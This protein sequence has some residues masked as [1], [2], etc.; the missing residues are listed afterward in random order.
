MS[1]RWG[2]LP[3][4]IKLNLPVQLALFV[5]LPAAHLWV[6][7]QYESVV[8]KDVQQRTRDRAIQSMLALNSMMLASPLSNQLA[9]TAFLNKVGEQE[10]VNDFHMVRTLAV[11][12]QFA[13]GREIESKEDE[14]DLLAAATGS[15]QTV[16]SNQGGHTLRMVIPFKA[17]RE[18]YGTDCLKC[19]HV[20]EGT[21]LG[22]ISQTVSLES[23]DNRINQLSA[24]LF[25]GQALLQISMFFLIYWLVRRVA[26]SVI[27]LESVVL[28]VKEFGD[29]SRR[30]DVGGNDEIGQIAQ[31]FNGFVS[32]IEELQMRLAEKIST[33]EQYHEQT[34]HE[35]RVGSDIMARINDVQSTVDPSVRMKIIPADSYSGDIIL[36]SRSQRNTLY[37]MLADAVGHGLIAAMNLL[38]L[39]QAFKAMAKKGFPLVRI[40]EELNSKINNL[41]PIDRFVGA[42]LVSI[43]FRNRIIE[44]WNGGLPSPILVGG[45]GGIL[46][47]WESRNLPLGI[48]SEAEFSPE[49]KV[50][51]YEVDCQLFV[52]SDGLT[53]ARSPAGDP[54]GTEYVKQLLRE[55]NPDRRFDL[56]MQSLEQHLGGQPAHDD[57]SVFMAQLSLADAQKIPMQQFSD[58]CDIVS[59]AGDWR[60]AISLGVEELKYLDIASMLAQMA[61]K[62]QTTAT[63]RSALYE[64]LSELFN[65][66]LDHGILRLHSAEKQGFEGFEKYLQQR[67]KRLRSLTTGL[68]EIEIEK[69]VIENN[70]GIRIH[71]FDSGDGFDYSVLPNDSAGNAATGQHGRG[72][73]LVRSLSCELEY[74]GKGNEVTAYYVID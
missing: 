19:H 27:N 3:L 30:A 72:I 45:H 24:V 68:I 42:V 20:P 34:Q 32:H 66:A 31:V 14:L 11:Q 13:P 26:R 10:G 74:A 23:V 52:F 64:I 29:F 41:M 61:D 44:I 73:A 21:V 16:I 69:I 65:N 25:A 17:E 67:E 51:H 50:F 62:I 4:Y 56:L 12:K 6:L 43:D 71:V 70:E 48:L 60:V 1:I 49:I 58:T 54:M 35:L 5:F 9:R 22:T 2:N 59:A 28:N 8:L 55:A 57:V 36:V 40:A 63:H 7:G 15:A 38:P 18:F 33:L 47:E 37:I 53:E 39:S 46:Y